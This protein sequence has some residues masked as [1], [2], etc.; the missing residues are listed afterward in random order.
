ML[1]MKI[2]LPMVIIIN[3][4]ILKI[5]RP[6]VIINL[7]MVIIIN[8][9]MVIIINLPMVIIMNLQMVR[10]M[11]RRKVRIINL[12]RLIINR[13]RFF[14]LKRDKRWFKK[15]KTQKNTNITERSIKIKR[16]TV[17]MDTK[18]SSTMATMKMR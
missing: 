7:P 14:N 9:P 17:R 1:M 5:N 6:K 8:L 18:R 12:Q 2:N 4:R 3:L 11:N 16:D 10:I 15:T 13:P